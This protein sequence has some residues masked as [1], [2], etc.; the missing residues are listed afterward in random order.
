M[1]VFFRSKHFKSMASYCFVHLPDACRSHFLPS[2]VAHSR[3]SA[4]PIRFLSPTMDPANSKPHVVFCDLASN[5]R[6]FDH[7]ATSVFPGQSKVAL[8]PTRLLFARAKPFRR[9]TE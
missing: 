8:R 3:A 9:I 6:V 2:V 5:S 4:I 7:Q 1:G